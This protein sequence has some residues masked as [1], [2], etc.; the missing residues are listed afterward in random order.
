VFNSPNVVPIEALKDLHIV[1]GD[2][3]IKVVGLPHIHY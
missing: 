1:V 2:N 3:K